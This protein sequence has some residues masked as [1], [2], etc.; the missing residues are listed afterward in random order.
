MN[1][2]AQIKKLHNIMLSIYTQRQDYR[3]EVA[4]QFY[5]EGF[6]SQFRDDPYFDDVLNMQIEDCS[7]AL[8]P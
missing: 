3:P 6:C 7:R 1:R 8:S 5:V 4:A 2:E